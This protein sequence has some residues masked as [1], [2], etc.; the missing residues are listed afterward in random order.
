MAGQLQMQKFSPRSKGSKPHTRLPSPGRGAP[1]E[2]SVKAG[3]TCIQKS[4]RAIGNR[5]STHK[6]HTQN[7][8]H[9][10]SQCRSSNLK[11]TWLRPTYSFERASQRGSRQLRL[12]LGTH[13]LAAA[14]WGSSFYHKDTGVVKKHFEIFPLA[15]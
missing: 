12:P 15:Y 3:G 14:I 9:S 11:G 6:W 5:D 1:R 7:L 10:E 13:M 2:L 4:Q 8:T